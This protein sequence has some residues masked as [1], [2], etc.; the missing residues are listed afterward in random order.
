MGTRRRFALLALLGCAAVLVFLAASQRNLERRARTAPAPPR[1]PAAAGDTATGSEG[2]PGAAGPAKRIDDDASADGLAAALVAE[3]AHE[4]PDAERIDKLLKLLRERTEPEVLR[5]AAALLACGT[6]KAVQLAWSLVT[7][8]LDDEHRTT[9]DGAVY[10]IVGKEAT[11]IF[12]TSDDRTSFGRKWLAGDLLARIG[13]PE[14]IEALLR[15]LEG[16]DAEARQV[17]PGATNPASVPLLSRA[18]VSTDSFA[19]GYIAAALGGTAEGRAELRRLLDPAAG[20]DWTRDGAA[21]VAAFSSLLGTFREAADLVAL[22]TALRE[23]PGLAK[24]LEQLGND[25]GGKVFGGV[26]V[27]A[28][29]TK[30]AQARAIVEFLPGHPG[31]PLEETL[32]ALLGSFPE[33]IVDPLLPRLDAA[34]RERVEARRRSK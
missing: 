3:C 6:T 12:E 11:T 22:D 13:T 5:A 25:A 7:G 10:A 26:Y 2:A 14:A 29:P 23:R 9:T 19:M 31:S 24:Y 33:R 28:P 16:E 27:H 34:H 1:V 32:L 4:R 30:S 17:M 8:V 21:K 15:M 20:F 18:L